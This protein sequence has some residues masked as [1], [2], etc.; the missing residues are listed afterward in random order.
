[1]A[2]FWRENQAF[3]KDISGDHAQSA[4]HRRLQAGAR[5]FARK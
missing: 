4:R 5:R 2:A 1:M 3:L